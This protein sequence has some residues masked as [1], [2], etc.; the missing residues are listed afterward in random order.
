[1]S[2]V[3]AA[4][5]VK[6]RCATAT[7][8]MTEYDHKNFRGAKYDLRMAATGMVLPDGTVVTPR[9]KPHETTIL[10]YPGETLFVSTHERLHVPLDLVGNMSITGGLS[11][12]GVLS[13]TGLIV[14]PGYKDGPSGDG[15]LH[16]RLANLGLR[17]V[18]F[19]PGSTRI[20]SIQF[21]SLSRAAS[22]N[23]QRLRYVW[24]NAHELQEG[25]GFISELK[26][27][28]E[29]LAGIQRAFE[30]QRRSVEWVVAAGILVIIATI[31]GVGLA[32]LLSLGADSRFIDSMK[33]LVPNDRTEQWISLVGLVA[34]VAVLSAAVVGLVAVRRPARPDPH[35]VRR[36]EREAYGYLRVGRRR[37]LCLGLAGVVGV[38]GAA[39]AGAVALH[40]PG[41]GVALVGVVVLLVACACAWPLCWRPI[42]PQKVDEQLARWYAAS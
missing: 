19:Q 29:E 22:A 23:T 11:R 30:N 21:L 7:P 1:M 12:E 13:L 42:T 16:F 5:D 31:L 25:L 24:D 36:T 10:L 33:N 39:V 28:K 8:L 9:D 4:E 34:L 17:P 2:G 27:L 40:W 3:L 6:A 37:W 20:A 14:D 15:R 26:S 38:T 41:F 35:G 32:S 18:A